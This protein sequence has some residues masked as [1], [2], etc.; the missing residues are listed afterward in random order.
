M[1]ALLSGDVI[2]IDMREVTDTVTPAVAVPPG[3]VAVIVYP[4]VSVGDTV[5]EPFASTLPI[6]GSIVQVSAFDE[7]HVRVDDSPYKRVSGS[8]L[9]VTVGVVT[10]CITSTVKY[11]PGLLLS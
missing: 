4:V 7:L 8:A 10:V 3:L 9:R 5:I 2:L 6:P 11:L 1:V